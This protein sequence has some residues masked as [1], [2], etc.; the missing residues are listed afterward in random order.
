M[1][2]HQDSPKRNEF[3]TG[4][5]TP[6]SRG[7]P[8]EI[9]ALV[10]LLL[11]VARPP[12][13]YVR[14]G[15]SRVPLAISSWCWGTRCGAPI[16][17]STRTATVSRGGTVHVELKFTPTGARVAVAGVREQATASGREVTW[18]AAHGGG[19][20]IKVTATQGWV[21]YVG[22]LKLR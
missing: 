17:A 15:G 12:A 8:L 11:G 3:F 10:A 9:V 22:R 14:V 18:R 21:I 4:P 16:A 7:Y 13:A 2:L 20:T 19:M 5:S 6:S 1:T